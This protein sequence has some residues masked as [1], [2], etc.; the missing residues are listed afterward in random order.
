MKLRHS[1]KFLSYYKTK[2]T[3]ILIQDI[4]CGTSDD[5]YSSFNC[6]GFQA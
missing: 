2:E 6:K 1:C 5:L 3:D 4:F